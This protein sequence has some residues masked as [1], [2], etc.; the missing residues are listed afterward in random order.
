MGQASIWRE[1]LPGCGRLAKSLAAP[2]QLSSPALV[3]LGVQRRAVAGN[4]RDI[5]VDRVNQWGV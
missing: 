2:R 1:P 5:V 3:V 4:L